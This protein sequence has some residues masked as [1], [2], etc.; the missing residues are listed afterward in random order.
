VVDA[1]SSGSRLSRYCLCADGRVKKTASR[2]LGSGYGHTNPDAFIRPPLAE[3]LGPGADVAAMQAL[4]ADD[5]ARQLCSFEGFDGSSAVEVFVIGTGGVRE[6]SDGSD[7]AELTEL[8]RDRLL[9]SVPRLLV[10]LGLPTVAF[11][12]EILGEREEALLEAQAAMKAFGDRL[13]LA[14]V[15]GAGGSSVQLSEFVSNSVVSTPWGARNVFV[16]DGAYALFRERFTEPT[17]ESFLDAFEAAYGAAPGKRSLR[18][19]RLQAERASAEAQ[20]GGLPFGGTWVAMSGLCI[21]AQD[22]PG[23]RDF[24]K[25]YLTAEVSRPVTVSEA[26]EHYL[27]YLLHFAERD[28]PPGSVPPNERRSPASAAVMLWHLLRFFSGD[29]ALR[30]AKKV[31]GIDLSVNAGYALRKLTCSSTSNFLV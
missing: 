10:G 30:F 16:G 1:G 6:A 22:I 29:A 12:V 20:P 11:S 24:A 4:F 15:I 26:R 18:E 14:G 8:F 13:D 17:L 2:S 3:F 19:I 21:A 5:L 27:R 28:D 9:G 25:H 7:A 23:L 31:D